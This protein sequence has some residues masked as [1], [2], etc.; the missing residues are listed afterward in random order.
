MVPSCILI[1]KDLH[2]KIRWIKNN[3]LSY[4]NYI[5]LRFPLIKNEKPVNN[6]FYLNIWLIH[7]PTLRAVVSTPALGVVFHIRVHAIGDSHPVEGCGIFHHSTH[8]VW[9]VPHGVMRPFR[10]REMYTCVLP[11]SGVSKT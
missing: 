2:V 3:E 6:F 8:H 11:N 4:E 10:I 5:I 1:F 9:M 7:F